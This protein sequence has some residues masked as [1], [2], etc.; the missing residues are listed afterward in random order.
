MYS[1][2]ISQDVRNRIR[3]CVSVCR[4]A[5]KANDN[6]KKRTHEKEEAGEAESIE[7]VAQT[8][9]E[10]A[11]LN[12]MQPSFV[13]CEIAAD[14]KIG[15]DQIS[16]RGRIHDEDDDDGE[17]DSSD[18]ESSLIEQEK[19]GKGKKGKSVYY[20]LT[21]NFK[22]TPDSSKKFTAAIDIGARA[23][24]SLKDCF[25]ALA[26]RNRYK[27]SVLYNEL[28]ALFMAVEDSYQIKV[29]LWPPSPTRESTPK[30]SESFFPSSL[31]SRKRKADYGADELHR[32]SST[33]VSPFP[34][35]SKKNSH[36]TAI[37]PPSAEDCVKF[38]ADKPHLWASLGYSIDEELRKKIKK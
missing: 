33:L 9:Y 4:A 25:S 34:A 28:Q 13:S 36:L 22:N 35:A 14:G 3:Q 5:R 7:R 31:L 20:I 27:N 30:Q 21:I 6:K 29:Y 19:V 37:N 32:K 17:A 26:H 38:Y 24:K 12:Q 11:T 1:S 16:P 23:N 8:L 15:R 18:S 10:H 2:N